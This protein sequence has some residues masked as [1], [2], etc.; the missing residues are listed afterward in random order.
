MKYK[1]KYVALALAGV[2]TLGAGMT[3]QAM[4]DQK[5][6]CYNNEVTLE[7]PVLINTNIGVEGLSYQKDGYLML[8]LRLT[9][10][11]LGYDV[12]WIGKT[13]SVEVSKDNIWTSIS[14]GKD[15]YFKGKA[16]PFP[17]GIAPEIVND[18]T[19]V[20]VE[21]FEEIL[22]QD[23]FDIFERN[24]VDGNVSN[25]L[26]TKNGHMITVKYGEDSIIFLVNKDTKIV[27]PSTEKEL[28]VEDIK[29]GDK[30]LVLHDSIMTRSL[31]P[32][33]YA[34]RINIVNENIV[35]GTVSEIKKT[36]DGHMLTVEYGDKEVIIFYVNE[37]TKITDQSTGEKSSI[38]D[39]KKGDILLVKHSNFMTFSI[40]PQTHAL[41]IDLHL[42]QVCD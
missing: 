31:P 24:K 23:A 8:P 35:E 2:L 27:D 11:R 18:S 38:K 29:E 17:L 20:P 13:R 3:S 10:E 42:L 37:E 19:Y 5:I 4:T 22:N 15:A 7:K 12:K 14:I 25:I 16:T 40:P 41:E 34:Y 30:L 9:C 36:K 32:Q 1:K 33:T 28:S 26:E 39:I 6:I 21:F